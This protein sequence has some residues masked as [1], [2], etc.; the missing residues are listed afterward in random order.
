M[1]TDV[2]ATRFLTGDNAGTGD[3][4]IHSQRTSASKYGA[5]HRAYGG[6]DGVGQ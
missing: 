1:T 2:N 5:S 3:W 4:R 6:A